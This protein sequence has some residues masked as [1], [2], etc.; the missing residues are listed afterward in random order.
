MSAIISKKCSFALGIISTSH[1]HASAASLR[2]DIKRKQN[3][4]A[5]NNFHSA[6]VSKNISAHQRGLKFFKHCYCH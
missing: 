4:K 2:T 1:T 3:K 5:L 6:N